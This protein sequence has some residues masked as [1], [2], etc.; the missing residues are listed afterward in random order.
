MTPEMVRDLQAEAER[1]HEE[2]R[3]HPAHKKLM[4]IQNLISLYSFKQVTAEEKEAAFGKQVRQPVRATSTSSVTAAAEAYLRQIGRRAQTNEILDAL[5]ANGQSFSS[6][7]P[8]ASLSSALSHHDAFDNKRGL[9]YGLS[10]WGGADAAPVVKS[11]SGLFDDLQLETTDEIS[12]EDREETADEV[13]K[14]KEAED[15]L[16]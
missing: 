15:A 11:A 12:P 1:L 3:A 5:K 10:E 16:A 7:N 14:R 13:D 6:T 4:A 8:V 9:G 2:L